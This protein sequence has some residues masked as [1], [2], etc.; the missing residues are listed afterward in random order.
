[1]SRNIVVSLI[2]ESADPN[3]PRGSS[4]GSRKFAIRG[5]RTA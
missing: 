2:V 3:Y 1:M 5:P 4:F